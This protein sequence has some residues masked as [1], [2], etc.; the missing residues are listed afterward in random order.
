MAMTAW[1]RVNEDTTDAQYAELFD[2]VIGTGVRDSAALKVDADSTGLNVKVAAGFGVVAGSAF[3]ST[4]VETLAITANPGTNARIDA[5]VLRRDFAQS[6]SVVKLVVKQ[7]VA[8]PTPGA[9]SLA[10]DPKGVFEELLA[11]VAVPAAAATVTAAN[12]TDKR[13]LLSTRVGTWTDETR[14]VGRAGRLGLNTTTGVWESHNGTEWRP[15]LDQ[16]VLPVSKGGTGAT[17]ISLALLANIGIVISS[18][19]PAPGTAILWAKR[20]A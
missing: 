16:G 13:R 6:P 18:T 9:P 3:L 17:A 14:P 4:A 8:A 1:P 20:G 7:G 12:V 5:V 11:L 15:L 2:S 10:Q 19:P